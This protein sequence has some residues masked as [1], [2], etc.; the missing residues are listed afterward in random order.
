MWAMP[1]MLRQRKGRSQLLL[2]VLCIAG[3]GVGPAAAG[4]AFCVPGRSGYYSGISPHEFLFNGRKRRF[5][6][7]VPSSYE[8]RSPIPLWI[9]APGSIDTA[10]TALKMSGI[11]AFAERR[12]FAV[13]VLEGEGQNLNVALKADAV[14][15]LPDDVEY[16]REVLRHATKNLCIDM[17]RIRCTGFSRGARFCSRLGSELPS[18]MAGIAPVGGIRF[19]QPNNATRPIPIIAFHGTKDP[20]NPYMGNGRPDYWHSSVPDAVKRWSTNNG[21]RLQKWERVA[22]K[23]QINTHF[24]CTN[25]ATVKLVVIEGGGHTWPGSRS[26]HFDPEMFGHTSHE[27]DANELMFSF[28]KEHSMDPTCIKAAEGSHCFGAVDWAIKEGLNVHPGWE[29]RLPTRPGREDWQV[30]LNEELI[31][32]CARPCPGPWLLSH[33]TSTSTTTATKTA[34]TTATITTA[35]ITTATTTRATTTTATTTT[36]TTTIPT[37]TA[38]TTNPTTTATTTSPTTVLMTTSATTT[39]PTTT[40]ATIIQTTSPSTTVMTITV[41]PT[42]MAFIPAPTT[43]TPSGPWHVLE[44]NWTHAAEPGRFVEA[45]RGNKVYWDGGAVTPLAVHSKDQFSTS[46]QG[47]TYSCHAIGDRLYWDDADVWIRVPSWRTLTHGPH[48]EVRTEM[49]KRF[50]TADGAQWAGTVTGVLRRR[51]AP[52]LLP[53]A[54]AAALAGALVVAGTAAAAAVAVILRSRWRS[55]GLLG[56]QVL[57]VV[58]GRSVAGHLDREALLMA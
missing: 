7:F 5:L 56:G 45:I 16:T 25:D 37:T 15:G 4:P 49:Q 6:A 53:S 43:S 14:P 57:V 12:H 1:P 8:A 35:T 2:L 54:G 38:T 50:A 41:A 19:P 55:I 23:V 48:E 11:D 33:T 51:A 29:K 47:K 9:L 20:V 3:A 30:L 17:E 58:A 42:T 34:T 13:V 44:G 52:G 21:C 36:P 10:E 46:W 24:G 28:F 26:Y 18:L 27:V 32:D 22:K 31:G 39:S 40:V